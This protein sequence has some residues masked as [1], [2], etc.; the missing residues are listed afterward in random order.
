MLIIP[1]NCRREGFIVSG[2]SRPTIISASLIQHWWELDKT[3]VSPEGVAFAA[4]A[5]DDCIADLDEQLGKLVDE[6]DRRGVLERTWL[7]IASDHGESFGE[8]AGVFC[9]GTSLYETELHV[10]LLDHSAGG[11]RDEAGRQRGGQSARPGGDDRRRGRSGGRL[12]ISRRISGTVLEA[13]F[14]GRR[15]SSPHP[16]HRRSPRWSRTTR[17]SAITG[18]C[19]S[20]LSPL[21]AVKEG[22]WSYIRREG[23]VRE[24]LFH[25]R[26]DAKEQRN[27]AGDPAAQTTLRADASS[28]GPP[29]RGASLARAIQSLTQLPGYLRLEARRQRGEIERAGSRPRKK[30]VGRLPVLDEPRTGSQ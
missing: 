3:T 7:I 18:V 9:H 11:Q 24:E 26:E 15:R 30:S 25:L 20:R 16:L 2:S 10:P 27:L 23:D 14:A 19:P 1:I 22:E 13:A 12:A 5:Y 28:A 17:T 6:L 4:D 29:D 8:H 21:G